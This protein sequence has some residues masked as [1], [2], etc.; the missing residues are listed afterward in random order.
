MFV[1]NLKTVLLVATLALAVAQATRGQS[2]SQAGL[3]VT[4]ERLLNAT[5]EP[6]NWLMYS[7]DYKSHNL[8][9]LRPVRKA[10]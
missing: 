5:A 2:P 10:P 7:G 9:S 4:S 6:G 3:P 1:K 8:W